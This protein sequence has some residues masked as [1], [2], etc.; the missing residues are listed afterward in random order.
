MIAFVERRIEERQTPHAFFD[1]V[2]D[3]CNPVFE[4]LSDLKRNPYIGLF[5]VASSISLHTVRAITALSI[6]ILFVIPSY[7]SDNAQIIVERSLL[8]VQGGIFGVLTAPC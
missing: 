1:M 6:S 7:I 8:H 5:A 2:E 4:K 3:Y